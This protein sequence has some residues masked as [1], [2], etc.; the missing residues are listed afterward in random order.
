VPLKGSSGFTNESQ[1]RGGQ[2]ITNE[3]QYKI[4]K[5]ALARL[6][7]SI[8]DF[9][10]DAAVKA[11]GNK[12]I[13]KAQL[14]ALKSESEVLTEQLAEYEALR[15][16]AIGDFRTDSL[17]ELPN[18]L[19]KARIAKGMSQ[20]Q[21]AERLGLKE[22]QIQRYESEKYEAASLRRIIEVA[23]ALGLHVTKHA[24][25]E[26]DATVKSQQD[27]SLNWARFPFAE[28]YRRGWFS[29]FKGSLHDA[30]SAAGDLLANF[31][32]IA[33]IA[34]QEAL[35]RKHVRSNAVLDDYALLAW[36]C[37][38]LWCAQKED[39]P[40]PFV[41]S[42]L[43]GDWIRNLVH[44][45]T[46]PDSPA[47]AA[48]YLKAAGIMLVIEPHLAQ[49]YLDGAAVMLSSDRAVIGM[50]LRYD[51]LDNF[52]F[53]LLHE[54]A[55]LILHCEETAKK[56][57]FDD[58]DVPGDA[59][60]KEAD[61]FASESLLPEKVWETA[62]ARYMRTVDTI[63]ELARQLHISPAIIA[64]RIRNESENYVILNELV[65]IGKVRQQFPEVKY[66]R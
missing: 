16:G 20:R 44:L 3:R 15:S 55:H 19:V 5:T 36:K 39:A 35:Y 54:L 24:R 61:R 51:R 52:W 4:T 7:D 13:A 66:G 65:G 34:P 57:F 25:L 29:G 1:K 58:L 49:T 2:L 38:V 26:A 60:E 56:T 10:V 59:V 23:D 14:D 53:V 8:S 50:T 30:T 37:R 48:E 18:L 22:Q 28:M 12:A 62:L 41:R 11:I 9:D 32:S 46:K 17:S 31:L 6:R 43:D 21:L 45:T 64:G 27:L 47:Q 40:V 33:G 42:K 63:N